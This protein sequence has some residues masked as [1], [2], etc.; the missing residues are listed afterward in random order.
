MEHPGNRIVARAGIAFS[1]EALSNND[2]HDIECLID[3][4]PAL[5]CSLYFV[6]RCQKEW[7]NV[8]YYRKLVSSVDYAE[9]HEFH[10][11]LDCIDHYKGML[12]LYNS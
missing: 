12:N 10:E 1:R 4:L 7:P 8:E 3:N 9:F 5:R 6:L 2:G 11:Q